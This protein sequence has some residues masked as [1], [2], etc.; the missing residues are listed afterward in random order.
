ME[1]SASAARRAVLM[2]CMAAAGYGGLKAH[3]ALGGEL[4]IT[5]PQSWRS[6]LAALTPA[7]RFAAFWGTVV[8]DL[9]GV[10]TLLALG[11]PRFREALGPTVTRAVRGLALLG[12]AVLGFVGIVGLAS[13]L[14]PLVGLWPDSDGGMA[15]WV[16]V[17][18]YNCFTLLAAAF[19]VAALWRPDHLESP[20]TVAAG[21]TSSRAA[22]A[23]RAT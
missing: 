17:V 6:L 18:V 21:A 5:D 7:Q 14:G 10:A 1:I 19:A 16:F 13:T 8:L 3:W 2:G 12:A 9:L 23:R 15:A 11:L 20:A 22:S 4:G